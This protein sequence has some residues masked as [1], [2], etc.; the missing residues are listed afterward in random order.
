M[1]IGKRLETILNEIKLAPAE[2][3]PEKD[4]ISMAS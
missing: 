1:S 4:D 2:E 3:S